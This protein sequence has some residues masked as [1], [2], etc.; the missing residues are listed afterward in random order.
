MYVLFVV[1]YDMVMC[2]IVMYDLCGV[3]K[4]RASDASYFVVTFLVM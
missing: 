3:V 4:W 2:I 1:N